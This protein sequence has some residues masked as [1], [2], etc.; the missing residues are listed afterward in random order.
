VESQITE[1][2]VAGT[3]LYLVF[4][5]IVAARRNGKNGLAGDVQ[6][7]RTEM[8]RLTGM[9]GE[10]QGTIA[11]S[12]KEEDWQWKKSDEERTRAVSTLIDEIRKQSESIRALAEA[13]RSCPRRS[14]GRSSDS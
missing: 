7:L 12:D 11:L 5:D 8:V 4:R 14:A 3:I 6:A 2:G 1:L 9:V 10:I 13:V